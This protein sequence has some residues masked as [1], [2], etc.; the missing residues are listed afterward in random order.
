MRNFIILCAATALASAVSLSPVNDNEYTGLDVVGEDYGENEYDMN[1]ENADEHDGWVTSLAQREAPGVRKRVFS[2]SLRPTPRP[3]PTPTTKHRPTPGD[4]GIDVGKSHRPR[5]ST[6]G[7]KKNSANL[8]DWRGAIRS[9]RSTPTTELPDVKINR[10][11]SISKAAPL[12]KLDRTE[13][14]GTG[15]SG[16]LKLERRNR[17]I[18]GETVP[19]VAP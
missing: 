7:V 15:P 4:N 18:N 14:V 10:P 9:G 17:I 6:V 19:T 3:L 16:P 8:L 13:S 1:E 11:S 12:R 2:R 5:S